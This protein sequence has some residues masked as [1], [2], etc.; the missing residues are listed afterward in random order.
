L[1]IYEGTYSLEDDDEG[2]KQCISMRC[3]YISTILHASLYIVKRITKK[4]LTLK[5]HF[6]VVGE[7]SIGNVDYVTKALEE[8]ICITEEKSHQISCTSKCPLYIPLVESALKEDSVNEKKL[9][10]GVKQVMEVIV[11]LLKDRVEVEKEP[12]IKK[13]RVKGYFEKQE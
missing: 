13:Q 8:L 7:E 5:S 1:T 4:S 12:V 11:G 2:S 6:E 10:D 9:C 3:E